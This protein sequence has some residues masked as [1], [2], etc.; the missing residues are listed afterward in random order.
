MSR[1]DLLHCTYDPKNSSSAAIVTFFD[2]WLA[3]CHARRDPNYH[4]QGQAARVVVLRLGEN[5]VHAD[6]V[7]RS[8]H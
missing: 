7:G 4:F 5:Q 1:L 6:Q 2:D 8:S 3:D